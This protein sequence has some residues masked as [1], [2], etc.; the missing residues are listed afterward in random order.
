MV[1]IAQASVVDGRRQESYKFSKHQSISNVIERG[2]TEREFLEG[3]SF[4]KD[5][6]HV[7]AFNNW[8]KMDDEDSNDM[9]LDL[10]DAI[11]AHRVR[12]GVARS[13]NRLVTLKRKAHLKGVQP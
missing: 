5:G 8:D 9:I 11:D 10:V 4:V 13:R 2:E 1:H 6:W 12:A 3:F 7:H